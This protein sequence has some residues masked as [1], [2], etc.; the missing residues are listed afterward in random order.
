MSTPPWPLLKMSSAAWGIRK[1]LLHPICARETP[2]CIRKAVSINKKCSLTVILKMSSDAKAKAK[3][4]EDLFWLDKPC[5]L[6]LLL[7]L[8]LI[9][10]ISLCFSCT[11][12]GSDG[13]GMNLLTQFL[14]ISNLVWALVMNVF[15]KYLKLNKYF[16]NLIALFYNTWKFWSCQH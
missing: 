5:H 7:I 10:F 6:D 14:T 1:V 2:S 12:L 9:Q 11:S 8:Y 15:I 16:V 4:K 13:G 3:A